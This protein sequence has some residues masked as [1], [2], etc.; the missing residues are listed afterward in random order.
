MSHPDS[1]RLQIVRIGSQFRI[2]HCT[3]PVPRLRSLST[4]GLLAA[5]YTTLLHQ[6]M[7]F[8]RLQPCGGRFYRGSVRQPL[9]VLFDLTGDS[10]SLLFHPCSPA[11]MENR[12]IPCAAPELHPPAPYTAV[13]LQRERNVYRIQPDMISTPQ[14]RHLIRQS[15]LLLGPDFPEVCFRRSSPVYWFRLWRQGPHIRSEKIYMVPLCTQ[16]HQVLLLHRPT[17]PVDFAELLGSRS[18]AAT[19]RMPLTP[20]E[21]QAILLAQEGLTNRAAARMMD[22]Q[23]GTVKKLL[24]TAYG[25]LGIASRYELLRMD[26]GAER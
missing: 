9:L 24:S 12:F 19:T 25:K 4:D 10:L 26:S 16:R 21:R 6:L 7:D 20:R 18:A 23:E 2:T 13:L 5:P 15:A 17:H 3:G 11:Q 8:A 1:G 14:S 22:V